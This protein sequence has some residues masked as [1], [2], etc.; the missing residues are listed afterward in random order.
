M[1]MHKENAKKG[2]DYKLWK[3]LLKYETEYNPN[4]F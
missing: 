2:K 1:K 3:K 4:N